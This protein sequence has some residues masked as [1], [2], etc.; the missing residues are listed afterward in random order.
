[1][2]FARPNAASSSRS[3]AALGLVFASSALPEGPS[4]CLWPGQ[5]GA[6]RQKEASGVDFGKHV[7]SKNFVTMTV[8]LFFVA[9]TGPPVL[10]FATRF[11]AMFGTPLL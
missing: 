1:M 11:L 10:Q 2:D 7:P 4:G 8:G 6:G 5:G 3:W 9:S